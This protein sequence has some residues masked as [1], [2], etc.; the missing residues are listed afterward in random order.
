MTDNNREK[1]LQWWN[2]KPMR[3]KL[4]IFERNQWLITA[5]TGRSISSL[6]GREIE[7]I[8]NA[9]YPQ[10]ST[11][12][13]TAD[14]FT[15]R[16]H[17]KNI[18]GLFNTPVARMGMSSGQLEVLRLAQQYIDNDTQPSTAEEHDAEWEYKNNIWYKSLYDLTC[19][20]S[21]FINDPKRCVEYVKQIQASQHEQIIRLSKENKELSQSS[22]LIKELVDTLKDCTERME[23]ARGILNQDSNSNWGMLH[24]QDSIKD[25]ITKAN[26]YLNK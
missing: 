24:V 21:E 4:T 20:G 9:E 1:A 19:G 8:Y 15:E 12:E 5:G 22:G 3:E 10:P 16:E 13:I 23:R 14:S 7:T 2:P 17:L 18:L 11:A 26:D 25:T 6:T